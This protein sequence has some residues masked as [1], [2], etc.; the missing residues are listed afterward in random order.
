MLM[1][2][3]ELLDKIRKGINDLNSSAYLKDSH[4]YIIDSCYSSGDIESVLSEI[5]KEIE[6]SK[7]SEQSALLEELDI[8]YNEIYTM[9]KKQNSTNRDYYTGFV[10]ACSV[11]EGFVALRKEQIQ[12][13]DN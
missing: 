6:E 2:N 1:S 7:T 8:V 12:N 9:K 3:L 5:E 4:G 11:L 13:K 10:S